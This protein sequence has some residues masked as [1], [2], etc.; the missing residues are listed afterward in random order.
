MYYNDDV[1]CKGPGG[2]VSL[3]I[4]H[5]EGGLVNFTI[6]GVQGMENRTKFLSCFAG[7]EA[8]GGSLAV[9]PMEDVT[10]RFKIENLC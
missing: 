1:M 6:T 4:T 8:Y 2:G 5:L 9:L 10:C 7:S 3:G